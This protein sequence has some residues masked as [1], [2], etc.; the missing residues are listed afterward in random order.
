[1]FGTQC[2]DQA[3]QPGK[4]LFK[5]KLCAS[6]KWTQFPILRVTKCSDSY[7]SCTNTFTNQPSYMNV[8][9][10]GKAFRK[11]PLF[12]WMLYLRATNQIIMICQVTSCDFIH[13]TPKYAFTDP[14]SSPLITTN[15]LASW[16]TSFGKKNRIHTILQTVPM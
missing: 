1:M 5:K 10:I 3:N 12:C 16:Q 6:F 4:T 8:C 9:Q 15:S 14:F 2:G 7:P 11:K 13:K